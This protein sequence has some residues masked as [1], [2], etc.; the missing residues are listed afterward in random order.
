MHGARR[1]FLLGTCGVAIAALFPSWGR[2]AS[3][4]FMVWRST[5]CPS[6]SNKSRE[7]VHNGDAPGTAQ[8]SLG[9]GY[10]QGPAG[11]A[12]FSARYTNL[13]MAGGIPEPAT[14]RS[15]R[16]FGLVGG[17]SAAA[18]RDWRSPDC[19]RG[20][21]EQLMLL[22]YVGTAWEMLTSGR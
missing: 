10:S 1:D 14:W 19:L 22:M 15:C 12:F 7:G 9:L 2:A 21:P 16:H 11:A 6:S 8:W 17:G 13:Q 3:I 4:A 5:I 18:T 20:W